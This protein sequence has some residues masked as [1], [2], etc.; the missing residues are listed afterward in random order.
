M[1]PMFWLLTLFIIVICLIPS[2]LFLMYNTYRPLK[3]LRRNEEFPQM[4]DCENERSSLQAMV[5]NVNAMKFSFRLKILFII[6][7]NVLQT[8]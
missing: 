6:F 7:E 8:R 2:Y 5:I 3:I 1:S 4:I